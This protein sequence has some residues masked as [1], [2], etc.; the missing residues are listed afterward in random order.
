[1]LVRASSPE[2]TD[3]LGLIK[4]A[5]FGGLRHLVRRLSRPAGGRHGHWR[6]ARHLRETHALHRHHG[7]H[8]VI[9][10]KR[11]ECGRHDRESTRSGRRELP[12]STWRSTSIAAHPVSAATSTTPTRSLESPMLRHVLMIL[13]GLEAFM[14]AALAV[15]AGGVRLRLRKMTH[16]RSISAFRGTRGRVKGS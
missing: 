12:W 6:H 13:V 4:G 3:P 15:E 11:R 9:L 16:G 1:M 8:R 7:G 2:I 10:I 5:T 14:V